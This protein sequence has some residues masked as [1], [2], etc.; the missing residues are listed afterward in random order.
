MKYG[1]FYY[2][3]VLDLNAERTRKHISNF[4]IGVLFVFVIITL[5]LGVECANAT[6]PEG[7]SISVFDGL[8]L[9]TLNI[10]YL[11]KENKSMMFSL[12]SSFTA[13][14]TEPTVSILFYTGNSIPV[15]IGNASIA[16]DV[17]VYYNPNGSKY[18]E[19]GTFYD[20]LIIEPQ[21]LTNEIFYNMDMKN[22]IDAVFNYFSGELANVTRDEVGFYGNLALDMEFKNATGL[23]SNNGYFGFTPSLDGNMTSVTLDVTIP[24]GYDLVTYK[25]GDQDMTKVFPDRVQKIFSVIKDQGISADMYLEWRLPTI[26]VTPWY[27][28]FPNNY[29]ITGAISLV[30]GWLSRYSYDLLKTRREKKR[31][32]PVKNILLERIATNLKLL[33]TWTQLVAYEKRTIPD[34]VLERILHSKEALITSATLG[35]DVISPNIKQGL[36]ELDKKLELLTNTASIREHYPD[37]MWFDEIDGIL[38]QIIALFVL[39]E[40]RSESIGLEA[41]LDVFREKRKDH[42]K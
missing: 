21:K 39:L 30:I 19:L 6:Y 5:A 8:T 7:L 4:S 25:F 1:H 37:G 13:R 11:I 15:V 41:W 38:S 16:I 9:N 34:D 31:N 40:R 36:L 42:K 35:V 33:G 22:V 32:E 24:E 2:W 10:N 18:L 17:I 26:T 27:A 28:Q 3:G 12:Q 23:V 20:Y 29:I 14:G